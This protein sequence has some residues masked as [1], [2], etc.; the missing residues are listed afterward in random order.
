M[1]Y[2]W[3]FD[4]TSGMTI[5]NFVLY[6]YNRLVPGVV[7]GWRFENFSGTANGRAC[8]ISYFIITP[9]CRVFS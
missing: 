1:Q 9:F 5:L 8:T 4:I 3:E 7:L 6:N 2:L